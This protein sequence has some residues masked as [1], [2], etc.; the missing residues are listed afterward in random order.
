MSLTNIKAQLAL[1][2][3]SIAGVARVYPEY[4]NLAPNSPDLPAVIMDRQKP[5][6]TATWEAMGY[7]RYTWHF[8][9]K[10]LYKPLGLDTITQWD[11]DIEPYPKRFLDILWGDIKLSGK[12]TLMEPQH[13]FDV[14]ESVDCLGTP[15]FG[16][17]L[18]LG[19]VEKVITTM[20]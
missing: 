9:I 15:Y 6:L 19:V 3:A 7:V 20:A 4:P 17:E 8:N 16:F 2:L 10:F 14:T 12:A 11:T 13:D 5:F 18:K 1:N